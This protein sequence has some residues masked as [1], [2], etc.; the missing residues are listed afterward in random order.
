MRIGR[1]RPGH[2]LG[3]EVREALE[4]RSE[5]SGGKEIAVRRRLREA[6]C[7]ARVGP[8]LRPLP[9]GDAF[10]ATRPTRSPSESSFWSF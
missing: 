9:R 4:A 8:G 1:S 2:D 5:T 7:R 10:A 6:L 3:L